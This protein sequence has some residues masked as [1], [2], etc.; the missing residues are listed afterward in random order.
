MK[1]AMDEALEIFEQMKNNQ[2]DTIIIGSCA[3][4]QLRQSMNIRRTLRTLRQ[5][6]GLSQTEVAERAGIS[7]EALSAYER[8]R[9]EPA[10]LRLMAILAVYGKT[11]D[12]TPAELFEECQHWTPA[13][14][15]NSYHVYKRGRP[16]ELMH[17]STY[18]AMCL[19]VGFSPEV[20]DEHV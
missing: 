18:V 6:S 9:S 3:A 14:L 4:E 1:T 8:G 19:A 7:Q 13:E 15:G 20:V 11:L 10:M 12:P 17:W 16:P 5:Q 2:A